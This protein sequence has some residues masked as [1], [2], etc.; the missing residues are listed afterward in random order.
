MKLFNGIKSDILR[1]NKCVML[2]I[3]TDVNNNSNNTSLVM[4]MVV[5]LFKLFKGL[6]SF[7]DKVN[8]L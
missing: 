4:Y 7:T 3:L 6:K 8:S 5:N 2:L 1:I